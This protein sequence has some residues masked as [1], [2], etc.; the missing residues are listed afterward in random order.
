LRIASPHVGAH[1]ENHPGV[2]I[3][4]ET[5]VRHSMVSKLGPLGRVRLALEW[6]L[7]RKGLGS[8]N[9]F[10]TGAFLKTHHDA[11]YANIQVEFMPLV[12]YIRN[13]KLEARA[14]FNY[15]I[16]LSRPQSRGQLRLR[17]ANPLV[18]PSI[19]FN[20]LADPSDVD[21]LVNGVQMVREITRQSALAGVSKG[22]LM[23]GA[24]LKS[25][26]DLAAW[27]AGN[28]GTSFHPSGTCRMGA[29]DE[30]VV[31]SAGRVHGAQGLRVIDASI[32]P[33]TVTGNLSAC[34]FML[35]EKLADEIKGG[36][37]FEVRP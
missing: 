4:F 36:P 12:R 20:H 10:E 8:T 25:R 2:N 30:A 22:E 16:D 19:V 3:Q 34:V 13:G 33:R 17:S 35:A 11:D 28:V 37:P 21:E 26:T 5:E 9:F 24:A 31:D 27:V 7:L 1:L 14:G 18:A 23:P 15:W 6:A 32:M 29:A